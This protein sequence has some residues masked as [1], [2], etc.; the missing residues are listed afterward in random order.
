LIP[1][2]LD[3]LLTMQYTTFLSSTLCCCQVQ[4][5]LQPQDMAWREFLAG[6]QKGDGFRAKNYDS[7]AATNILFS[8]GTTGDALLLWIMP[9]HVIDQV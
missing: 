4:A 7:E 2:G 3:L 8:S 5:E 9:C 6:G 1:G